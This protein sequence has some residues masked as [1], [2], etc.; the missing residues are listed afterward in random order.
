MFSI[1]LKGSP[2]MSHPHNLLAVMVNAV[3]ALV[4]AA[5]LVSPMVFFYAALIGAPTMLC[6]L[7][8]IT[9]TTRANAPTELNSQ[10]TGTAQ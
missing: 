2:S 10:S 4:L 5:I 3:L 9:L 1:R 8:L 6:I 7:V